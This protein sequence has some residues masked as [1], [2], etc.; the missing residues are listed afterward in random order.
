MIVDDEPPAIDALVFLLRKAEVQVI[1]T[2]TDPL[3]A[4]EYL[5]AHPDQSVD[6]LFVDIQMPVLSGLELIRAMLNTRQ[7]EFYVL[8]S[9]YQEYAHESYELAPEILHYL[10]KPVRQAALCEALRRVEKRKQLMQVEE[11]LQLLRTDEEGTPFI[12]GRHE[13]RQRNV[14]IPLAELICVESRNADYKNQVVLTTVAHETYTVRN[15][16]AN[17]EA[18]LPSP[19]FIRVH[20]SAI[21]NLHQVTSFNGDFLWMSNSAGDPKRISIGLTYRKQLYDYLTDKNDVGA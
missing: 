10:L 13:K 14:R 9:A 6:V 2:T 17:I 19:P 3:Q 4:L 20:K 18:S 8:V 12:I 21:I 1:F 15:T 5:A 7:V 16:L 11:K